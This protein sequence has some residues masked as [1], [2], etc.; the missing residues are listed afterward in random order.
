M[1]EK[2][3]QSSK[4]IGKEIELLKIQIYSENVHT[5]LINRLALILI[6]FVSFITFF[7]STYSGKTIPMETLFVGVTIVFLVLIPFVLE[8]MRYSNKELKKISDMIEEVKQGKELST[9]EEL[10]TRK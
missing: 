10:K 6:I 1:A 4:K 7:Y 3:S 5:A 8:T 9:L 2:E